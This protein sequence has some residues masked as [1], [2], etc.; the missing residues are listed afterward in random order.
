MTVNT[1]FS[2]KR[3]GR[4]SYRKLVKGVTRAT[5]EPGDDGPKVHDLRNSRGKMKF[6]V[7]FSPLLR[8]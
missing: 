4:G 8:G 2:L 1:K 7:T 5:T 3:A 6:S